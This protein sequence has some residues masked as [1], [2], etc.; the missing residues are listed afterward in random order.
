MRSIGRKMDERPMSRVAARRTDCLMVADTG[1]F[2][3]IGERL[4]LPGDIGER[5]P[6]DFAL[7]ANA[8]DVA[9]TMSPKSQR[10]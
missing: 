2:G 3:D 9:A 7:P 10:R 8:F 4:P 1:A 5:L 6:D